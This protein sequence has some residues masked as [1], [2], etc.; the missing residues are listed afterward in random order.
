MDID[1][2]R[3]KELSDLFAEA[4]AKVKEVEE[5]DGDIVVPSINELRYVGY[6][7]IRRWRQNTLLLSRS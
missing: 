1:K 2:D 4:E 7:L 5:I 3:L 6:H